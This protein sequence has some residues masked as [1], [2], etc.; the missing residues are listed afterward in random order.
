MKRLRNILL[1]LF[2]IIYLIIDDSNVR[3][4][5]IVG[6]EVTYVC[7]GANTYKFTITAYRDCIGGI[8]NAISEDNP[9]F[10]AI[11]TSQGVRILIDSIRANSGGEIVPPNFKNDCVTNPPN[12]CLN[13]I[14]FERTVTLNN[15]SS[16]FK[17]VYQRCCR[18][19]SIINIFD[20][21]SV[22]ATYSCIIPPASSADC[23]NSAKFR[24]FP[25]QIICVNNPLVYDHSATDPDGDSLSYEFCQAYDGGT[26]SD[27]KPIPLFN[28][29]PLTYRPP[30]SP[31][32][33]MA[34]SPRIQI[35]PTTGL[36]TG[37]PTLQGRFVVAVCCHEWRAG[38]IIN[39]VT[40]EFQFVVTNCS[41]A[42][43]A[44]IP[45]YSSEY[46][47]YIVN[48]KDYTVK[49]DNL[50]KGGTTYHWDFGISELNND[51][52]NLFSPSFVY[53]DS[54]T[55]LVTLYVNKGTTCSDS[56]SRF[57]KVY[58]RLIANYSSAT[59]VCP[60]DT[61]DF[62]DLSTS[63]YKI[64]KW[65]WNFDDHSPLD[66]N[67]NTRHSFPFGGLYNVGL[68]ALNDQGCV[69]TFFR[70]I[71][72]DPFKPFSGNDTTIVKGEKINFSPPDNG[73]YTWQ[74]A[75]YL[76]DP[77]IYNPV[78]TFTDTGTFTYVVKVI[79]NTGCIAYDTININVLGNPYLAVP[80][81]FTPNG[82]GK[83]D[84]FRPLL[85]GY[86]SVRYF[87]IYNRYGE[88]IFSTNNI[89]DAWDG[90][91]KGQ[92]QELGTYYWMLGVKDRFGQDFDKKGDVI[93]IR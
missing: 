77:N 87:R 71:L 2:L 50:S 90:T 36:I 39:T 60:G 45:Q 41:K 84:K 93:L 43:V 64:N 53:P 62:M 37:T 67:Q 75:T 76:S 49:F 52:S 82:D 61:I 68:I 63:T 72:V 1:R 66:T 69:D 85:V 40:R 21:S 86:Q 8:A 23:N 55:F 51:T 79:S 74:P 34:G 73:R 10:F 48:C 81:A 14:I 15:S 5:H 38:R 33:P 32:T 4:T 26:N 30:Y 13:K 3:A 89:S 35:N 44:D 92:E 91:Y 19:A 70:K 27:P 31:G 20:P 57:V 46:N 7:L 25:P 59:K 28:A 88:E 83:N 11:Y 42:V 65:I 80:N 24:N 16:G 78:G 22:G 47:T 29:S 58:P 12:T 18:N 56:I 17:I 9:A 54:G 6:G